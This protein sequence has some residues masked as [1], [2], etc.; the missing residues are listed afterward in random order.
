M[1]DEHLKSIV[2]KLAD[3]SRSNRASAVIFF[4]IAVLLQILL[5]GGL[6][7]LTSEDVPGFLFLSLICDGIPF[8]AGIYYLR[9]M[10]RSAA[11]KDNLLWQALTTEPRLIKTIYLEIPRQET[12]EQRTGEIVSRQRQSFV[13]N[14]LD[15]VFNTN[16]TPDYTIDLTSGVEVKPSVFVRLSDGENHRV[17]AAFEAEETITALRQHA[18]H[19]AVVEAYYYQIHQPQEIGQQ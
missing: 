10:R 18:P 13:G 15:G 3:E 19:A 16:S 17:P 7:H 5:F 12:P 2:A 14:V 6:R 1:K 11:R 4:C 8:V 9:Q